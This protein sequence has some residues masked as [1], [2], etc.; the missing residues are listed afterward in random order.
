MKRGAIFS[1]I[2]ASVLLVGVHASHAE[3]W[4]R[5]NFKANSIEAGYY[6]TDSIKVHGKIVS[7]TEKYVYTGDG[8]KFTADKLAKYPACKQAM[9]KK[10]NAT[11][12]LTDYQIEDGKNA[13]IVAKK[14][15]SKG[16]ELVCSGK[17]MGADFASYWQPITRNSPMESAYYDLV[18]KYKIH[19][20]K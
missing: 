8:V 20:K 17:D 9:A 14:Y 13:R 12:F 16:N 2:M 5:S 7:W 1:G 4:D 11:Y 6:D 3:K 15:Y 19:S 10:G 18:T